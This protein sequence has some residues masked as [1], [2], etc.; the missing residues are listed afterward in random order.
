MFDVYKPP[1]LTGGSGVTDPPEPG[2]NPQPAGAP[3]NPYIMPVSQQQPNAAQWN[4]RR[5]RLQSWAAANPTRA[6]RPQMGRNPDGSLNY[7]INLDGS[8]FSPPPFGPNNPDPDRRGP[9]AH[10]A[11]TPTTPYKP[12]Y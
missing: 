1:R 4:Q 8:R 12:Y 3:P 2:G 6:A 5:D 10:G 9:N 11:V 7:G